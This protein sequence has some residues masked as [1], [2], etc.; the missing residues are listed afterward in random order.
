MNASCKVEGR[1]FVVVHR[2]SDPADVFEVHVD[3]DRAG[4]FWVGPDGSVQVLG[5][6]LS[7]VGSDALI[8]AVAAG[9][10]QTT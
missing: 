4:I 3:G 9:C 7:R 10:M 6:R 2:D 1:E 8:H 5:Y